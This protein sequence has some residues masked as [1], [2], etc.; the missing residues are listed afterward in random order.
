MSHSTAISNA[1]QHLNSRSNPDNHLAQHSSRILLT[2][3][4]LLVGASAA[5]GS[6]FGYLVGSQQHILLGLVFAGAALGGEIVKPFAVSEIVSALAQWNIIRALA[7]LALAAVCIVYSFTAELSLAATTRGDLGS[8][9]VK[10]QSMRSAMLGQIV[11][12]LKLS[13][14]HYSRRGQRRNCKPR[15]TGYCLHPAPKVATQT[16][17]PWLALIPV[18]FLELG[19]A[20]AVVVVRGVNVGPATSPTAVEVPVVQ[21]TALDHPAPLSGPVVQRRSKPKPKNRRPPLA[22]GRLDHPGA[23]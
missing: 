7:C 2:G 14:L 12:A 10:Q 23:A 20:L 16:L 13:L 21:A 5:L 3:A 6:Y 15:S 22:R 1:S 19:S 4:L 11:H 18:A 9:D 17:L 8:D